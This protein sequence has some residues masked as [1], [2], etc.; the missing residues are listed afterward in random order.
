MTYMIEGDKMV[1]TGFD[2]IDVLGGIPE[3][4]NV[5]LIAPPGME[6][7]VFSIKMLEQTLRAGGGAI[8]VTTD[9]FPSDIEENAKTLGIDITQHTNKS[10]WFIDCYSWTLAESERPKERKDILVP[11]PSA[12]NDLSIGVAQSLRDAGENPKIIFQ[13]VSTLLLYNN[14]EIVFRFLQILGA[15]LKA[16]NAVTLF[17]CEE[18]MH[19]EKT[20]TTLKHLVDHVIE[21][22]IEADKSAIRSSTLGIKDWKEIKF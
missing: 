5:L 1:L 22:K 15:R 2:V 19:D 13:S 20:V 16:A 6:K 10:L 11:G 21:I 3:R 9:K 14:P 7:M 4:S 12:L 18:G 8:Y 17:H